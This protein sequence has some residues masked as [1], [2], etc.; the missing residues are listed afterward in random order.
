MNW[1][2][3]GD[4]YRAQSVLGAMLSSF[5]DHAATAGGCSENTYWRFPS[6]LQLGCGLGLAG[7]AAAAAGAAEAV[8]L[9]RE[10]LALQCGLINAELNRLRLAEGMVPP[11]MSRIRS[12]ADAQLFNL[13]QRL[14][15]RRR[16]S[17]AA[18]SS[19]SSSSI[20]PA[21]SAAP[22]VV[23][24]QLFDWAQPVTL[25]CF[26]VMLACDVLYE[27][28]SVE[29]VARVVPKLLKQD[30]RLL[31]ADPPFRAAHNRWV[32]RGRH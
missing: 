25:P 4:V 30:G 17:G 29:A 12:R 2:A 7:L 22:G 24:A 21:V 11:S 13:E 19:S 6:A 5:R 14:E 10:P 1:H 3:H 23:R 31:L 8:L 9:D 18:S 15:E 26:D 27:E 16:E 28:F 20:E 32:R